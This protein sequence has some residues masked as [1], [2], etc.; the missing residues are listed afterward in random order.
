MIVKIDMTNGRIDTTY[1]KL[2]R[3]KVISSLGLYYLVFPNGCDFIATL[4]SVSDYSMRVRIF[5]H[6][7]D[8]LLSKFCP[9]ALRVELLRCT[10]CSYSV[11]I[12]LRTPMRFGTYWQSLGVLDYNANGSLTLNGEAIACSN[13]RRDLV[14]A[15]FLLKE[16][17]SG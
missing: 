13:S 6:E 7:V 8:S 1:G 17:L 5:D 4:H 2:L 10:E 3:E 15:E 11:D 14:K 12:Q 9:T 16:R